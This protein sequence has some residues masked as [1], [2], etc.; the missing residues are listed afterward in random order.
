MEELRSVKLISSTGQTFII[1]EDSDDYVLD[2]DGLD[3]GTV[4]ATHNMTQYI[5]LVGKHLDSTVLSPRDISIVGWIIGFDLYE[6]KKKKVLLDKAINPMYEIRL[7]IGNYALNF[8]PD[9][10][11]QFSRE[12]DYNNGYMV[13][14]QIQGTAPMPLFL[15]KDYETYRKNV[16]KRS[17]FHF[18]FSIPKNKGVKF[19]YFPLESIRTMPNDGDVE[20]GM[21]ITL[22]AGA[23]A[24]KNPAIKN[25]TTNEIIKFNM[26]LN[27]GEKLIVDTQLGNQ[28]ATLVQ[29]SLKTNAMKYLTIESDID[30]VLAL[31]FNKL[32]V[33]A[34]TGEDDLD[35]NVE[36]SPRFLEVEGR[37]ANKYF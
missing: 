2:Q 16:E 31:G 23:I 36:F 37:Y 7:E 27:M 13:K 29:G 6:I 26:T 24:T 5:D 14:F 28:T 21:V 17:D 15:L 22:T 10:S 30:M 20:S 18:P 9:T 1:A 33:E 12:W 11:I 25:L 8:R 35:V 3:L 34:D 4:S 32:S 19:G